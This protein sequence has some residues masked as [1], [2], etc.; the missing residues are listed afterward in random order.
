MSVNVHD[1]NAKNMVQMDLMKEAL[2][3][4]G[5]GDPRK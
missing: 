5:A 4:S 1:S 2:L 3:T